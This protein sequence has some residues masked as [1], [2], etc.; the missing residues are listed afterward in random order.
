MSYKVDAHKKRVKK[1]IRSKSNSTKRKYNE[2]VIELHSVSDHGEFY[3]THK[4][5]RLIDLE[6][7]LRVDY[8]IHSVKLEDRL[9]LV[10]EIHRN[11]EVEGADGYI[12]ISDAGNHEYL[13][14]P[15]VEIFSE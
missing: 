4:G 9:R 5:E 11:I 6:K 14:N 15:Y 1:V 2:F 8:E 3:N 13:G 10:Y 12:F 7:K